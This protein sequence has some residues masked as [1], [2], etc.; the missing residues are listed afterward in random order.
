MGGAEQPVAAGLQ[1]LWSACRL[2]SCCQH[3]Q[4]RSTA[5]AQHNMH[6][7]SSLTGVVDL[8]VVQPDLGR[9]VG[10]GVIKGV[11]H[12]LVGREVGAAAVA[13][14]QAGAAQQQLAGL[15]QAAHL[16]VGREAEEAGGGQ[17]HW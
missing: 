3:W 15:A 17:W 10:G 5:T 7:T 9:Q 8:L 14:T 4:Q 13:A 6:S 1:L 11:G 2:R 16:G 12:K